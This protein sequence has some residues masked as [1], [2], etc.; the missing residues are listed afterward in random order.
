MSSSEI[1]CAW[2]SRSWRKNEKPWGH[3]MSWSS[4]AAGHGKL[5][6]L[7][8][9]HRTSLKYNNH[10]C[11]TLVIISGKVNVTYGDEKSISMPKLHPL[12]TETL[13][14]G[15]CLHVYSMCPYRISAIEDSQIV[16]IGNYLNDT[17]TRLE[18]DYGRS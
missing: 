12:R 17:P 15:D 13:S 18:D 1:K 4:F 7:N 10:K 8:K 3:E 9:G 6:F 16:E 11:E 14:P 5:L 2:V